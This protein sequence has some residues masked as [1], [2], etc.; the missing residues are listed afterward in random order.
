MLQKMSI[1]FY[2]IRCDVIYFFANLMPKKQKMWVF[3]SWFGE[4]Y[5]GNARCF[6]EYVSRHQPAVRAVW[7]T[8]NPDVLEYVRSLGFTAYDA[9]SIQGIWV[10]MR[11][12][13]CVITHNLYD[14]NEYATAVRKTKIIQL[15]RGTPFKK[16]PDTD[17]IIQ[18]P[19]NLF[20]FPM[21][22][23]YIFRWPDA[24]VV[25]T[26]QIVADVYVKY[27]NV[28]S[29]NVAITGYPRNDQL[30]DQSEIHLEPSLKHVA[31]RMENAETTGVFVPH[32]AA[33]H[34]FAQLDTI[35]AQ[36]SRRNIVLLVKPYLEPP[37]YDTI[38]SL[39]NIIFIKNQETMTD[40]YP[41]LPMTD[42]LITDYAS[43]FFDYL[44]LDK[45][46]FFVP[47]EIPEA[48]RQSF[49][50]TYDEVTPGPHLAR[51]DQVVEC[52]SQIPGCCADYASERK[53]VCKRFNRYA[54]T[55]SERVY[56]AVLN[57]ARNTVK[58]E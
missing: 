8:K 2:Y 48:D 27:F 31:V 22:K 23:K 13:C 28:P 39:S 16:A 41:L 42:F 4:K 11:A 58:K 32:D 25:A 53:K 47:F 44:M 52:L 56:N 14:I 29:R 43:I 15:R 57:Y 20:T 36:L 34:F 26:S 17:A 37:G 54:D 9:C 1:W 19:R 38:Q 6:F 30:F 7:L 51:W 24:L 55:S 45:P 40:I 3:G 50:Y 35:N 10:S 46:V 33:H 21:Y 12:E 49:F 18:T 5:W